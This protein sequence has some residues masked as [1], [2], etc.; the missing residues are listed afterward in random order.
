MMGPG[1]RVASQLDRRRT[2]GFPALRLQ[3]LRWMSAPV[4]RSF[5]STADRTHD[6]LRELSSEQDVLVAIHHWIEAQP[7]GGWDAE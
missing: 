7:G 2:R 4:G 3:L 5:L 1:F 6:V